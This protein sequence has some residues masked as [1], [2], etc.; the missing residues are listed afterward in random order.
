MHLLSMVAGRSLRPDPGTARSWLERELSAPEYHRSLGDRF[1][2]WL[3]DLWERLQASAL[4]ASPLSTGAA[5]LV[6][7]ALTVLAVTVA[8]RV[9]RE[10]V[11]R[12]GSGAPLGGGTVSPQEHRMAAEAAMA[13][14]DT[15]AAV[16]EAFRAVA[17]RAVQ[18]GLLEERRG[19]TAREL[20]AEL[21]PFLPALA[22]QL[23]RSSALFDLVFYGDGSA[24][25]SVEPSTAQAVLDLDDALRVAR[26]G[27]ALSETSDRP[28]AVP[29]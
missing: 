17:A 10:P 21:A 18:R 7:A 24:A 14:G 4:D 23:G 12:L 27:R 3:N 5:V 28:E 26:P 11:V 9:R 8:S 2:G 15:E 19:R 16:V 1:L 25:G 29:R 13:A 6:L 20:A 22:G